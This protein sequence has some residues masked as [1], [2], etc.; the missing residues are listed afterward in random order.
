MKKHTFGLFLVLSFAIL[1]SCGEK[2]DE[3]KDEKKTEESSEKKADE[4]TAEKSDEKTK[5]EDSEEDIRKKLMGKWQQTKIESNME[6]MGEPPKAEGHIIFNEATFE[7]GGYQDGEKRKGKWA[8]VKVRPEQ[9]EQIEQ[10]RKAGTTKEPM[11]I[12]AIRC[13]EPIPEDPYHCNYHIISVNE[14]EL[15]M[16]PQGGEASINTYIYK[17]VK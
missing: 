3:K 5:K 16:V 1:V 7:E 9:I 12:A 4:K 14:N 11:P 15:V 10:G 13:G 6:G 17:K 2:K 8:F